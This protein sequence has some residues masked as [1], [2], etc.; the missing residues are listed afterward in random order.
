M[1]IVGI[2]PHSSASITQ[3]AHH[4]TIWSAEHNLRRKNHFL[5]F[6]DF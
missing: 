5:E 6:P 3:P 1:T 2:E 4:Y